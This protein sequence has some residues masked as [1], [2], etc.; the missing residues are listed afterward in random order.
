MREQ[1]QELAERTWT[2]EVLRASS[3]R[4]LLRVPRLPCL[5]AMVW[6]KKTAMY[7]GLIRSKGESKF[8]SFAVSN[9]DRVISIVRE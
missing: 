7:L 8:L 4:G 6:M 3:F 1:M 5:V 2:R 9:I